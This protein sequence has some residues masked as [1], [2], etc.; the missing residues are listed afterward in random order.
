MMTQSQLCKTH[1][2]TLLP[3]IFSHFVVS[4]KGPASIILHKL[5]VC[6]FVLHTAIPDVNDFIP[7]SNPR[8]HA[9]T[10]VPVF[11]WNPHMEVRTVVHVDLCCVLGTSA[12]CVNGGKKPSLQAPRAHVVLCISLIIYQNPEPGQ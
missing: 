7:L 11:T 4:D 9:C 5:Y 3:V 1:D 12:N 6:L 2:Q 8:I 10:T